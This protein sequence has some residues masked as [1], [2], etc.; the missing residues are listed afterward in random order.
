MRNWFFD[1]LLL[2]SV[3][4]WMLRLA[5]QG[6][7]TVEQT[8]IFLVVFVIL[9]ALA[10]GLRIRLA[11][12]ILRVGLPVAALFTFA[13]FYGQGQRDQMTVILGYVLTLVIVLLGIYVMISGPFKKK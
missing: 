5:L 3:V 12:L 8:A 1:F 13:I 2:I 10:R 6:Y 4:V 11:R 7:L 9:V